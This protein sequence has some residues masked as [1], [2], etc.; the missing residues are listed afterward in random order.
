MCRQDAE[1]CRVPS[2]FRYSHRG[3]SRNRFGLRASGR[4]RN[5][6]WPSNDHSR[7]PWPL[8]CRR[9]EPPTSQAPRRT[10]ITASTARPILLFKDRSCNSSGRDTVHWTRP[11]TP[12]HKSTSRIPSRSAVQRTRPTVSGSVADQCARARPVTGQVP[13]FIIAGNLASNGVTIS[14]SEL[15]IY[16]EKFALTTSVPNR[17]TIRCSPA[18]ARPGSGRSRARR[19]ADGGDASFHSRQTDRCGGQ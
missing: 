4:S 13:V 11:A 14:V 15:R 16:G 10:R 17:A 6:R 5:R 8:R 1:C 9:D 3:I 7:W 12:A 19:A 18:P 2:Q